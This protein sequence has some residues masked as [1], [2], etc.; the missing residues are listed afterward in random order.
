RGGEGLTATGDV[1]GTLRYMSPEQASARR[2]VVDH[3]T[4][5]YS[6]GI[7]LYELL[8]LEPAIVGRD[9]QEILARLANDEPRPCRR[10]NAAISHD[11]ETIVHKALAKEPAERYATAHALA[12]D[13]GRC[14]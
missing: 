5:I 9:R 11:L 12:D 13:L 6:L 2:G 7:T 3:R 14:L 1:L 8:T 10:I 4:D